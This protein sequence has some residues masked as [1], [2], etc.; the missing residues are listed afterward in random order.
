M[1]YYTFCA[2]PCALK[3]NGEYLGK[4][5]ENL[6][7]IDVDDGFLEFIPIDSTFLP[8]NCFLDKDH[9]NNNKFVQIIDLY[10]GFLIIPSF[11]KRVDPDFKMIGKRRF[12]FAK[13]T[14]ICCFSQCGI[15]L[16]VERE[17][18]M[19]FESL[20]FTPEDIRFETARHNGIDYVV[21]ICVGK[22]S[23]IIGFAFTDKIEVVFRSL[24]DGYG[25]E[26][27]RL[28]VL[29][30]KRDVLKHTVSAVWEFGQQVKPVS[31]SVTRKKQSFTLNKS[32]FAYAF[33]EE[34]LI[35]GDCS[36]FLTPRLKPKARELKEFLGN[37]IKV[38]PPPHFKPDDLLTLLYNDKVE[39]VKLSFE[40]GLIDNLSII[41]K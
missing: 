35:N 29:E 41:D 20:P 38:L 30:N 7:F 39:Y 11:S 31:Y 17:G 25:F 3:F 22:R 26:K 33:F 24:C 5:D 21:A 12:D 18:M 34:I 32:L 13:P 27:N 28:S 23:L 8:I 4:V 40:N 14:E 37:F 19:L 6:S 36:D 15:K 1:F 9:L 2:T 10:G 16:C